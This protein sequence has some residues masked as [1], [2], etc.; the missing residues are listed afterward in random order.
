MRRDDA[1]CVS[2]RVAQAVEEQR[3]TDGNINR[4]ERIVK[5]D[6]LGAEVSGVRSTGNRNPLPLAPR[7]RHASLAHDG[8]IAIFE[9]SQVRAELAVSQ[10]FLVPLVVHWKSTDDV[11]AHSCGEDPRLLR[12]NGHLADVADADRRMVCVR[13]VVLPL[14][15]LDQTLAGDQVEQQRLARS[16]WAA[17]RC[18]LRPR[19]AKRDRAHQCRSAAVRCRQDRRVSNDHSVAVCNVLVCQRRAIRLKMC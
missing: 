7:Y 11:F 19:H 8:Q 1:S 5:E 12:R 14:L 13:S 17:D 6:N 18:Q 4:S 15:Q 16:S 9:L 2:A 10:H 3:S